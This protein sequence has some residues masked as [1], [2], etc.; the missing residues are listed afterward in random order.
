MKGALKIPLIFYR[1]ARCRREFDKLED[2][3]TCETSHARVK[4]AR[5]KQY[6]VGQY[7]FTVEVVFSN[8]QTKVYVLEELAHTLR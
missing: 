6:T 3:Q 5:A 2:A 1:C 8:G 4:R 7:P